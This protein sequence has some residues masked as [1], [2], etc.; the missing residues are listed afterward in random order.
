ME[1]KVFDHILS[2]LNDHTSPAEC[3]SRYP[4]RHVSLE[5]RLDLERCTKENSPF[6]YYEPKQNYRPDSTDHPSVG[7]Q[8]VYSLLLTARNCTEPV[9]IS[10]SMQQ[11]DTLFDCKP[12]VAF[13]SDTVGWGVKSGTVIPKDEFLFAYCGEFISTSEA[14]KRHATRVQTKVIHL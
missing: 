14:E 1:R 9:A 4:S 5:Q 2:Y 12:S 7:F 10:L 11:V 8:L 6:I 13:L 3:T